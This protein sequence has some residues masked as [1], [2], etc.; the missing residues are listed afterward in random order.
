MAGDRAVAGITICCEAESEPQEA[1]EW[2]AWCIYN[3]LKLG[4][5]GSSIASVCLQ[6]FA[7][8]E[9]N[10][11]PADRDNL[12]RVAAKP[13]ADPMFQEALTAFDTVTAQVKA[14]ATD[15]TGG[16]THLFADVIQP[17]LWIAPAAKFA[18]QRGK[19]K[20]YSNVK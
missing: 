20:F 3:R 15:P 2:V 1:K 13:E 4:R 14:G 10:V 19:I 7:F 16:A 18:G 11:D 8:S 6:R 17:P 9:W 5:F 12:R